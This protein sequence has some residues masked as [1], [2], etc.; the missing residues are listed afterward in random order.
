MNRKNESVLRVIA[1]TMN[2]SVSRIRL[3]HRPV[4]DL[5]LGNLDYVELAMALEREFSVTIDDDE[6]R[7]QDSVRAMLRYVET[8]AP[9]EA[10][11]H[12]AGNTFSNSA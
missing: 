12:S 7:R 6:L 3:R 2:L 4:E 9:A 5:R 8:A 10:G 1:R 11:L